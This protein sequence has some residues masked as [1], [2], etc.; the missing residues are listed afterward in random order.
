MSHIH[1]ALIPRLRTTERWR[2]RQSIA[3]AHPAARAR[4]R[5]VPFLRDNL[6]E[7][8]TVA[9]MSRMA[10][11]SERTLRAAFR[12][13]SGSARSST[14][15]RSG[16]APPTTRSA[17]PIRR[18]RP[19]P[20][21][22]WRTGSSSSA[23]LPGVIVTPSAKRRRGRCG[24]CSRLARAGGVTGHPRVVLFVG[25]SCVWATAGPA[26]R[27]GR[28]PSRRAWVSRPARRRRRSTRAVARR[29][30]GGG[31]YAPVP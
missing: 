13:A 30:S 2:A 6:G 15:S 19:S 16:C 4:R 18:R 28:H 22:R 25:R 29:R 26:P 5:V 23:A 17:P 11:V 24:S 9:E 31:R 14:P 8:V 21:S 10:G 12:D 27:N 1:L 20:T 3:A 7:P